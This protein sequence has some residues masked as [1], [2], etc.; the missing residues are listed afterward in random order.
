MD[1]QNSTTVLC[2]STQ[3]SGW[4]IRPQVPSSPFM[5]FLSNDRAI[6]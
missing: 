1:L 6:F 4:L 3:S 5:T 2:T